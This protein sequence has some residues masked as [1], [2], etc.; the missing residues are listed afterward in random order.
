MPEHQSCPLCQNTQGHFYH[1]DKRRPYFQCPSCDLVFVP[2][3]FHLSSEL[4]KAEYDKH[5]NSL[6]DPGYLKFLSRTYLAVHER[7]A[8]QSNGLDFGCGPQPALAHAMTQLGH[9]MKV[10]DV[11]Y[12]TNSEVLQTHY[13]FVT[14][15]EV[16][17]H[18][19]KPFEV[20]EQLVGLL[21]PAGTL[22][23]M[24][25]LVL[26][27]DRF[28]NWHYKN[29]PTHISFFSRKTFEFLADQF[30]LNLEF[31]GNDVMIFSR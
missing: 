27:P 15:T 26:N 19:A 22:A 9:T 17:E 8:A 29:D 6:D 30:S 24:T 14:C 4:E 5:E 23:I 20:F 13:D 28:A 21:K 2:H 25:K 3:S 18:L 16:I 1:Q 12:H 7:V 31:V 11:F 10:Y